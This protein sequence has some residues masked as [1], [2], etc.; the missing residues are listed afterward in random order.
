MLLGLRQCL[1]PISRSTLSLGDLDSGSTGKPQRRPGYLLIFHRRVSG[2]SVTRFN[3]ASVLS[4]GLLAGWLERLAGAAMLPEGNAI[5][6]RHKLAL[7]CHGQ[8]A[9]ITLTML[10]HGTFSAP[11]LS[12][13]RL[14]TGN[15][16]TYPPDY[17]PRSPTHSPPW[18]VALGPKCHGN[19][20][21]DSR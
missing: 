3:S 15:K 2:C 6:E 9:M 16:V 13:L 5:S 12:P 7:M 10:L 18:F 20:A 21:K 4:L 11:S 14:F 19:A 17:P 1:W 8:G